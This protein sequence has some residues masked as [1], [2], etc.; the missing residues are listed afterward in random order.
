MNHIELISEIEI[1]PPEFLV[2]ESYAA[3][4][5][6]NLGKDNWE[7]G[8][9]ITDDEGILKYNRQWR[10]IDKPTDVLSFVQDEGDVIPIIPGI[11]KEAGDV[12]ISLETVAK[13]ARDWDIAYDEEL[14][15]VIIHGIL[16][17]SGLDHPDDD[18]SSGMLKIQEEL[19]AGTGSLL[20]E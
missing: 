2:M 12:I 18:Y 6:K 10:N 15:R 19:L 5:L 4:V 11:P 7:M 16:H 14:R 9:V 17:L 20:K 8:L 1:P 13:N 3:L